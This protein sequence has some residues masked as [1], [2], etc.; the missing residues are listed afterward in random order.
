MEVIQRFSPKK[1]F[2]NFLAVRAGLAGCGPYS[3]LCRGP[4]VGGGTKCGG[5]KCGGDQVRGGG[6]RSITAH[7]LC[8]T[9]VFSTHDV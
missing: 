6:E 7:W 5:T 9:A 3:K 8:A 2:L 1:Q 4:S